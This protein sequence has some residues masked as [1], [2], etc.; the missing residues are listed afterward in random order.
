[1][2]PRNRSRFVVFERARALRLAHYASFVA[3]VVLFALRS[4]AW[5]WKVRVGA[6]SPNLCPIMSSVTST[7]MCL[8]PLC[9]PHVRPTNCGRMVERRDQ[10]LITALEPEPRAFSAFLSR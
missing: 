1:H 5:P 3:D 6:N 4:A 7:G 10:I 8:C 2:K 9:T